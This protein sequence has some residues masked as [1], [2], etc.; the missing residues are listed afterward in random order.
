M[1]QPDYEA[2]ALFRYEIR[3][4][5][6]FSRQLLDAEG[7]PPAQYQAIL[8]IKAHDGAMAIG[9]LAHELFIK[10]Q[11]AVELVNRMQ[12]AG[13]VIRTMSPT[14]RRRV[15]LTLT[16][17]AEQIFPRLAALHLAQLHS[18]APS[19]AVALARFQSAGPSRRD[20]RPQSNPLSQIPLQP[21]STMSPLGNKAAYLLLGSR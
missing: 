11:T 17:H 8:A 15:L 20:S 5:L 13:L 18:K 16:P 10:I 19:F 9:E 4:F 3:Q 1:S 14:D 2:L 7:L 21:T 6:D 12:D